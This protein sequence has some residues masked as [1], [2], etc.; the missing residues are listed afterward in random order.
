MRIES[1]WL[2]REGLGR[3]AIKMSV[4]PTEKT[5]VRTVKDRCKHTGD[6]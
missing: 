6:G 3:L 4:S 1:D 5:W 2:R